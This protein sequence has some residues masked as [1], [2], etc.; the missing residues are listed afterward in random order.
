M[1]GGEFK[2]GE[3]VSGVFFISCRDASEVFDTI[4]EPLDPVAFL[5]QSLTEAGL[6]FSMPLVRDVRRGSGLGDPRQ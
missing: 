1:D 5:I 3:V 2:H 6:P 4:E